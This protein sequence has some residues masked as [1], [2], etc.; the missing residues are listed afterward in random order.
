[1]A[2]IEGVDFRVISGSKV[3][4]TLP[5]LGI[6][7]LPALVR[8]RGPGFRNSDR[9]LIMSSLTIDRQKILSIGRVINDRLFR[10]R[11]ITWVPKRWSCLPFK[12]NSPSGSPEN[13]VPIGPSCI[14][15]P[16][17]MTGILMGYII[18]AAFSVLPEWRWRHSPR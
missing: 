14:S 4:L 5:F 12:D 16:H 18:T 6:G 15:P 7:H 1:M 8:I 3:A 2:R 10:F 13:S 17:T 9:M 11:P